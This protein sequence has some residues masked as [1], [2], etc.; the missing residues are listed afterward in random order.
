MKTKYI[1]II[2][3]VLGVITRLPL[4]EKMQSHWD[5]P[6]YSIAII[7]YNLAQEA[8]APP[9]Y[10]IYI[11]LGKILNVFLNDPHLS[12]LMLGVVF[13]GL[14]ACAF[15][16][17]G[18]K[19]F[20]KEAGIIASLI[21][22]SSPA[23][24][25]FGLTPYAY[26][27]VPFFVVLVALAVRR[28]YI[29]K[30]YSGVFLGAAFGLFL[31][32][33]PQDG[34]NIL[35]LFLLGFIPLPRYEK[36]RAVLAFLVAVLL[37]LVPLLVLTGGIINYLA[38]F[39][40]F[41]QKGA[42]SSIGNIGPL[43]NMGRVFKGAVLGLGLALPVLVYFPLRVKR[44]FASAR[45]RKLSIFFAV[46][47]LPGL[48]STILIR[49]D[50]AGYQMIYLTSLVL[51]AGYAL[52]R[53]LGKSRYRYLVIALIALFNLFWFFRDRDP[54]FSKPFIPTSFHYSEIQKNDL[55]LNEKFSFIRDNFSS[56]DSVIIIAHSEYFRPVMYHLPEFQVVAVSTLD[57]TD[58]RFIRE[59]RQGKNWQKN[60][61]KAAN[62]LLGFGPNAKRLVL[63][64]ESHDFT[65]PQGTIIHRLEHGFTLSEIPLSENDIY[66]MKFKKIIRLDD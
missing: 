28:N 49:N 51:L 41:L 59:V 33:R 46:W 40:A 15:Y 14:T 16:L 23:F 12:L 42:L 10:P 57:T 52:S 66:S 65:L 20:S 7:S 63:F 26:G 58:P 24:Y 55:I 2:L 53:V 4:I 38:Q 43:E 11:F 13:S 29:E 60:E 8:P 27:L 54:E 6:Q 5:G 45:N 36:L 39:S 32:M 1:V 30:K 37:W 21:Y 25:F 3:F 44:M 47:I 50:H 9:G 31:G 64:D 34:L 18:K 61:Y 17:A 22:L 19:I 35:P 48:L 62:D 56:Q